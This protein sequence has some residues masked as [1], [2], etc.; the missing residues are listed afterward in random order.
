MSFSAKRELGTP[1]FAGR[2]VNARK[3]LRRTQSLAMNQDS[4]TP[5]HGPT[6]GLSVLVLLMP[7]GS[8]PPANRI[9]SAADASALPAS[10]TRP[11]DTAVLVGSALGDHS[12]P[13][14]GKLPAQ[15]GGLRGLMATHVGSETAG[16]FERLSCRVVP[17]TAGSRR[18]RERPFPRPCRPCRASRSCRSR[19]RSPGGPCSR[20]ARS[21]C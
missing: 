18:S 10:A 19:V 12:V 9:R 21:A 16:M 13:G 15:R 7:S 5:H 2:F 6:A 20:R 4:P 8:P 1:T 17:R 3:C 14:T 11:V